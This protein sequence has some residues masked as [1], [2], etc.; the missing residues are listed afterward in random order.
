L[1]AGAPIP[2]GDAASPEETTV[3]VVV[4]DPELNADPASVVVPY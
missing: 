2:G 3:D 1:N 4:G